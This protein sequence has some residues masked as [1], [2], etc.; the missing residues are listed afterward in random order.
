MLVDDC[1]TVQCSASVRYA[2]RLGADTQR[3][4]KR[5]SVLADAWRP[6]PRLSIAITVFAKENHFSEQWCERI[7]PPV[8]N[9][10]MAAD[11][12]VG[13]NKCCLIVNTSLADVAICYG[14]H[15]GTIPITVRCLLSGATA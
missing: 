7:G 6:V 4:G 11:A 15:L 14:P 12:L 2:C 5:S 10:L 9:T 1:K 3:A 13:I 8:I